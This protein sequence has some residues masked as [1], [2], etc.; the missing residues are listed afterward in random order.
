MIVADSVYA[1]PQS[2]SGRARAVKRV[3]CP[4]WPNRHGN[5]WCR[6]DARLPH[7]GV[8][9][10]QITHLMQPEGHSPSRLSRR[11]AAQRQL[12]RCFDAKSPRPLKKSGA[13]RHRLRPHQERLG[14]VGQLCRYLRARGA[15][16]QLD[17][18]GAREIRASATRRLDRLS[19]P[20]VAQSHGLTFTIQRERLEAVR[21]NERTSRTE[22]RSILHPSSRTFVSS[23]SL[24]DLVS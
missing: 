17:S 1:H 6:N 19:E 5:V 16:A 24:P 13:V 10:S 3:I 23:E 14:R 21:G 8:S 2:S 15:G 18:P 7:C 20:P 9:F 22:V 11:S 4:V 12:H